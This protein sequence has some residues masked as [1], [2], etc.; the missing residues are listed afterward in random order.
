MAMV[1]IALL[2][3]IAALLILLAVDGSQRSRQWQAQ[4]AALQDL[5]KTIRD[6][7]R[8]APGSVTG[9]PA[10]AE[11]GTG[12]VPAL[13]FP[14]ERDGKHRLGVDFLLPY[15]GSHFDQTR[16][17]G[18]LREFHG[19]PVSLNALVNNTADAGAANNLVNDS[20]CDNRPDRPDRWYQSLATGVMIL[21]DYR[22]FVFRLRPGVRW[23]RPAMLD[24]PDKRSPYAWLDR[25][26]PLTAHDFVFHIDA[27]NHPDVKSGH[28]KGYYKE[29]RA[30][31]LDDLTLVVR[32]NTREYTN[33]SFSLGLSPLP[34][35]IYGRNA[36]GTPTPTDQLGVSINSHWFD[37]E[38]QLIGVGGYRLERFIPDQAISFLRDD[39]YW[40]KGL[41]FTRIEWDAQVKEPPAQL[42]SFKN[43][44]VHLHG[45]TPD[46]YKSEILDR[47]EPRFAPL[48][49]QDPTAG[50]RSELAWARVRNN[51]FAGMAW[52]C[53]R[54]ALREKAVR[55]ALAHAFDQQR[56][57]EDIFVGLARP[58]IGPVHPDYPSFNRELTPFAY[59][60]Y[61]A[62]RLL[63]GAGWRDSDGDGWR[64]KE[65][66]GKRVTLRLEAVYYVHSSTWAALLNIYR[67]ALRQAQVEL[68]PTGVDEI[69]WEKRNDERDFDG[70]VLGWQMG[71]LEDDFKQI[72]HSSSIADNGSNIASWSCPEADR[73]IEEHRNEFGVDERIA[74]SRRFQA[75]C[76][77]EQPYLFI[78][79]GE[80]I[81]TWQNPP[82]PLRKCE[83]LTGIVHGLD[84][85]H[86]LFSRRRL[87]WFLERP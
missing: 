30:W 64:D 74:L 19:L 62:R 81:L 22:L 36:D 33:I 11:P 61:A 58:Q 67:D 35:H 47:Q 3:L 56:V 66:D 29:A 14:A 73:L 39:G 27:I 15:D 28:L 78:S 77:E 31:A 38:H 37:A 54:P 69:A 60:L 10:G 50:R 46:Q 76:Q 87:R 53:A 48:D 80:G 1:K 2:V 49:P 9:A 72:W 75:V 63:D 16:V 18:T 24:D 42:T 44:Q 21:D 4:T 32:W 79:S 7:V 68:V 57:L 40:G 5:E 51:S 41:H 23:Q 71:D 17:G 8:L 34:R 65:I 83:R 13:A 45:L 6:G 20:L 82:D 70:F 84:R 26:W 12:P 25:E 43:G 55:Q 59:D 86:P 85:Y 52:N